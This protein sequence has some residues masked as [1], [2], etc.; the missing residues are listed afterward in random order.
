MTHCGKFS[1]SFE[2]LDE[3]FVLGMVQ[4]SSNPGFAGEATSVIKIT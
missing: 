1:R 3:L 4:Q 2:I